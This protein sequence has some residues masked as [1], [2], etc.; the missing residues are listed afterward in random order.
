ME[1]DKADPIV[2]MLQAAPWAR[3]PEPTEVKTAA[4]REAPQ[5]GPQRILHDFDCAPASTAP[6]IRRSTRMQALRER[7]ADHATEALED[8]QMAEDTAGTTTPLPP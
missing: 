2:R 6:S 4:Q 7:E 5:H 8:A 3:L 1:P